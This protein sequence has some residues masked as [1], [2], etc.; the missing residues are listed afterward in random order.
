[1]TLDDI[2]KLI[3]NDNETKDLV[4]DNNE[5]LTVYR[6]LNERNNIKDGYQAFLKTDPYIE[7]VYL[8]TKEKIELDNRAKFKHHLMM[9]DS[10]IYLQDATLE[11]FRVSNGEREKTYNLAKEFLDNYSNTNYVKG[12]FIYGKYGTG[13]TYMLSAIANEL[14]SRGINVLMVFMP[15]LVRNIK[16]GISQ[17]NMEEKIN[18][19]KQADI[20]MLDDIGGENMTAWFRDEI[21]LPIIQYRL[22]A[23][24][25]MFF[26]SN[27]KM[28]E[29]VD[30]L[31]ISKHNELDYVKSVRLIQRIRD[32]TTYIALNED[33]YKK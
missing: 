3:E 11:N 22:S 32:L 12:L 21:L 2:R 9:F 8:P 29:L 13:K 17:G 25:P 20:L 33:Q 19:L 4:L 18:Q 30:A 23:K 5:L 31:A 14:A 24:L 27:L 26:S 7:L 6:Y 1:M 16:A 15:D 10:D 28:E